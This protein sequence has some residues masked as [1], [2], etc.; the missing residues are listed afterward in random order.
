VQRPGTLA[1]NF[2]KCKKGLASVFAVMAEINEVPECSGTILND[3]R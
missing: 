1:R 3:G 2:S